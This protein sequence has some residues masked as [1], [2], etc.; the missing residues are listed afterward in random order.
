RLG[1][2]QHLE[3]Q[4]QGLDAQVTELT[5]R[6]QILEETRLLLQKA[7]SEAR[8]SARSRLE[9]TVTDALRYVF[10]PDFRFVIDIE[11]TARR[12]EAEFY[13]ESVYAGEV[14]RTKPEDARGGG[15]IDLISI[16][17]RV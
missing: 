1:Q 16:A 13:V 14:V 5:E 3:K 6:T 9:T 15:V 7:G 8:E 4:F 11:E 2:S 12:A 10:G 17:L